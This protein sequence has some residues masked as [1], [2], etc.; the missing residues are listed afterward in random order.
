[1]ETQTAVFKP[2]DLLCAL[3]P[4]DCRHEVRSI[5]TCVI[6]QRLIPWESAR[7]DTC[8]RVCVK[9]LLDMQRKIRR[10]A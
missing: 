5:T 2:H 9:Q 8:S 1:M 7:L 6:C 4:G 3:Y 10:A